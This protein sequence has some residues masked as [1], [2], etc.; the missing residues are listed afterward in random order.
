MDRMERSDSPADKPQ[1][2]DSP[3]DAAVVPEPGWRQRLW[4]RW[5]PTLRQALVNVRAWIPFLLNPYQRKR[6]VR[7]TAR[8]KRGGLTWGIELPNQ[9]WKCGKED[10]LTIIRVSRQVRAFE[11][12][13]S[14]V[15]GTILGIFS[16]CLGQCLMGPLLTVSLCLVVLAVGILVFFLK[17]WQER[18]E[19]VLWT[20]DEHQALF[21]EPD[22]ATF[23]EELY[24]FLPTVK[25]AKAADAELQV[26]RRSGRRPGEGA[27]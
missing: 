22:V 8:E 25:L 23:E 11:Y 1:A 26:Q 10:E 19:L 18:V 24:L 14:V 3:P 21:Q 27:R 12:P 7:Y 5:Q 9:C 20:C 15:C 17:S 6:L 16:V 4:R 2:D 13:L